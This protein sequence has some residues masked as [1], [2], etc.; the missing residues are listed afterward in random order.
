M[1][2]QEKAFELISQLVVNNNDIAK[3]MQV[4]S[5]FISNLGKHIKRLIK[6][7]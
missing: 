2:Y 1:V 7:L 5:R 4:A 3:S 6:K